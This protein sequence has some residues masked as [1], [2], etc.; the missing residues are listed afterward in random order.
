MM[1]HPPVI[2]PAMRSHRI[3][4]LGERIDAI[5]DLRCVPGGEPVK[6]KSVYCQI[7]T[8]REWIQR[9]RISI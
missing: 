4:D 6:N 3:A 8:M 5:G 2:I 7:A 1:S 9:N